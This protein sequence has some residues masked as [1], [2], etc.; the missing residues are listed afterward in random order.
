MRLADLTYDERCA[1]DRDAAAGEL[2]RALEG[3]RA[4]NERLQDALDK[5]AD[6]AVEAADEAE[7]EIRARLQDATGF[8]DLSLYQMAEE[9]GE[10]IAGLRELLRRW[11]D[12]E[13]R[14]DVTEAEH[15]ALIDETR[16][17]L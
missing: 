13:D 16:A 4:E 17:A 7:R 8:R 10:R 11:L 2:W 15:E 1:L 3:L 14:L 9:V 5:A 12:H 6:D